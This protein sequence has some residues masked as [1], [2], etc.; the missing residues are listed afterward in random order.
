MPRSLPI[1]L[2]L[3][4][5]ASCSRAERTLTRPEGLTS[6]RTTPH[7]DLHSDLAGEELEFQVRWF[8]AFWSWF[9]AHYFE[10]PA[11]PKLEIWL[12]GDTERFTT[13]CE[14]S[15]R[16]CSGFYAVTDNG[17][18]ILVVD[19]TSGLGTATHEFVHHF[20]WQALGARAPYWWNEGFAAF[21]EKF[22]AHIDDTGSLQLSVGYFS[23]WRF[24]I[25]KQAVDTYS[26]AQLFAAGPEVDQCAARSLMLFLHREGKLKAL[27]QAMRT[28]TDDPEGSATL[29]QVYGAPLATLEHAW[30]DWIRRQPL[31]ADVA[32]VPQ[33]LLLTQAQWEGWWQQ[34]QDR[35]RWDDEA[36]RY[37]PR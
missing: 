4:V 37:V 14:E 35:L 27:V 28:R 33:S 24:P 7:F 26:L 16:S 2:L 9:E 29:A 6:L 17:R 30:K 36:Q 23:N 12:V 21:F 11:G 31:D 18:S 19:L 8:T 5:F 1:L 13:W 10:I 34:R 15:G 25:C 22:L 3:T 20:V 32:L